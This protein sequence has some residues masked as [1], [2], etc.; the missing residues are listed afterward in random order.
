MQVANGAKAFRMKTSSTTV[1]VEFMV[2]HD[3]ARP[4]PGV[5]PSPWFRRMLDFLFCRRQR[6]TQSIAPIKDD[7]PS[8]LYRC[9]IH[10]AAHC[11]AARLFNTPVLHVSTIPNIALGYS[12]QALIGHGPPM[13]RS[14]EEYDSHTREIV[15]TIDQHMPGHGEEPD[16]A[17]P[18]FLS[19]HKRVTELLAGAAGEIVTFGRADDSRS[20]S[21]YRIAWLKARSICSSAVSTE[22]FLE[23]ALTEAIELITPYRPVLLAL[24][25]ELAERRELDGGAV[26]QII[27]AALIELERAIELSRRDDWN[28]VTERAEAFR[29]DQPPHSDRAARP[30]GV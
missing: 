9:S 13:A 7:G 30:P 26:D 6:R 24:A 27:A 23:F 3:S 25:A 1:A 11:L 22:A 18:W 15:R 17:A 19:V 20:R 12:G 14:M 10:E 28:R 29:R 16:D 5:I 8:E 4:E 21:D 2:D